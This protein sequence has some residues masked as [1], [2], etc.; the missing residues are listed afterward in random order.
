MNKP[1]LEDFALISVKLLNDGGI[2]IHYKS[3][4]SDGTS[5]FIEDSTSEIT[6]VP[7]P[8]LVTKINAA[9]SY[10]ARVWSQTVFQTIVNEKA[11]QATKPQKEL[12]KKAVHALIEQISV[13]GVA[14]SGKNDNKG[15]IITGKKTADS[16]MVMAM[17]S[18]RIKFGIDSWGFEAE[19]EDLCEIIE[20]EVY[21]YLY[22]GKAAQ[23]E[24][25]T[26]ESAKSED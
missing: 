26:D 19:L 11:F 4:D 21:L 1:K 18:H 16:G 7:H 6:K 20:K 2:K 5:I 12:A 10:L 3:E 24:M 9:V 8:D 25:F 14:L 22:D 23:Q 13:T 15:V 17:N